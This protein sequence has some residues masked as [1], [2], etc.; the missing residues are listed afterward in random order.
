[1]ANTYADTGGMDMLL[2]IKT[3]AANAT[4]EYNPDSKLF[5]VKKGSI[6]SDTISYSATFRGAS[7]IEKNRAQY[8]KNGMVETDAVFKS[9]STAA[10]FVTGRST[11]GLNAWRDEKGISLKELLK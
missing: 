3:R 2:Y 6:V 7:T 9:P 5:I 4:G 10:N 1:M 11:N 8:V